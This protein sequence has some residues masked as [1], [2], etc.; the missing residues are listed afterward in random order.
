M[1]K[2]TP[3]CC[4]FTC[5]PHV[6]LDTAWLC[7]EDLNCKTKPTSNLN[8]TMLRVQTDAICTSNMLHVEEDRCVLLIEKKHVLGIGNK[9]AIEFSRRLFGTN[10]N[11]FAGMLAQTHLGMLGYVQW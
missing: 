4:V 1:L 7:S 10:W 2:S 9:K 11:W 3:L 8:I 5:C 6:R